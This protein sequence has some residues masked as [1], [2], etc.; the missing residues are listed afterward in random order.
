MVVSVTK[1]SNNAMAAT[2]A[3]S[4]LPVGIA[5]PAPILRL[6]GKTVIATW[7]PTF[8]LNPTKPKPRLIRS[9][10]PNARAGNYDELIAKNPV[11]VQGGVF[12][13][14]ARLLWPTKRLAYLLLPEVR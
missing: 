11:P 6:S 2:E 4:F 9:K 14:L 1:S 5:V 3:P 10:H 13:L 8:Q 12:V 7:P